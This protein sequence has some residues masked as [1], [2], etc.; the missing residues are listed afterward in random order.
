MA[1]YIPIALRV[2]GRRCLVVGGGSTAARRIALLLEGGA[3]V[4]VVAPK[5]CVKIHKWVRAGQ[6]RYIPNEY[7]A[8]YLADVFLVVTATERP[9]V[10][11]AVIADAQARGILCNDAEDPERGNFVVPAIVRRGN[12]LLAVTTGGC[13]PALAA[14]I[15]TELEATYGPEYAPYV[16]LLGE[17]R[18]HVLETIP[19]A[20]KR[21][22]ALRK[23][24]EEGEILTLIQQGD[25]EDALAKALSCISLLSD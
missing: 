10:N 8:D 9:E 1:H 14:R 23:V 2:E 13:S 6:V 5:A 12:L 7:C 24:A 20:T 22:E 16:E 21:Q 11:A 17:V 18:R 15:R 25:R 4:V 3:D 19:D